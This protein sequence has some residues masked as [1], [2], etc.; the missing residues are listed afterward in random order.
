[1]MMGLFLKELLE[2]LMHLNGLIVLDMVE[3]I[4]NMAP[5]HW[6]RPC[7]PPRIN[8]KRTT[9]PVHLYDIRVFKPM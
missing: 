6:T 2:W 4:K 3:Y 8:V 5:N 1:M 7:V 9:A